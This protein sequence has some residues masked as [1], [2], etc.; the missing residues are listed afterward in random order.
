LQ[1]AISRELCVALA[2]GAAAYFGFKHEKAA[3]KEAPEVRPVIVGIIAIILTGISAYFFAQVPVLLWEIAAG[4][5]LG[6]LTLRLFFH[7]V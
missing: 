2:F 7:K 3:E 6:S 5:V 4:T 1:I